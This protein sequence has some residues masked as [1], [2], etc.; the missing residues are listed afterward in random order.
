MIDVM[1]LTGTR[2]C[3]RLFRDLAR[4]VGIA[5]GKRD[6]ARRQAPA[7]HFPGVGINELLQFSGATPTVVYQWFSLALGQEVP[8]LVGRQ[9]GQD[10]IYEQPI[11]ETILHQDLQRPGKEPGS[12][13]RS[14]TPG[15]DGAER[16]DPR[17]AMQTSGTR[18]GAT[19]R[20]LLEELS[21]RR[22][23]GTRLSKS[24]V[25]PS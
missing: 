22:A 21:Q 7:D 14:Q 13:S 24:P 11:R 20:G 8:Q 12:G 1:V 17:L 5:V 25:N 9:E 3:R 18:I 2:N 16:D 4:K 15:G 19:N 6:G 10:G 23:V